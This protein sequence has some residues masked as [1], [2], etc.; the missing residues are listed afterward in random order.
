MSINFCAEVSSNHHQDIN[1]CYDFI[2]TAGK[3]GCKSVKF[4]LFKIEELFHYR[5]S[6][7]DPYRNYFLLNDIFGFNFGKNPTQRD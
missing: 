2:D 5:S 3:I 1:R 4:Q 7:I 6:C